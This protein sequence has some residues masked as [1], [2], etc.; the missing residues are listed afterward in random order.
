MFEEVS[1]ESDTFDHIIL[2][3]LETCESGIDFV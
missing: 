2:K 1:D 3:G